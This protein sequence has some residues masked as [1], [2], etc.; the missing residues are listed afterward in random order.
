[1]ASFSGKKIEKNSENKIV[2]NSPTN[3]KYNGEKTTIGKK[4]RNKRKS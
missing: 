1:M 3:P 4:Q 2:K